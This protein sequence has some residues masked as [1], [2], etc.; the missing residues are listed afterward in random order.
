MNHFRQK[1]LSGSG[2]AFYQYGGIRV[3]DHIDSWTVVDVEPCRRLTLMMGM[4]ALGVGVLEFDLE[5]TETGGTRLT[6]TAYWHPAGLG[7]LVYWYSLFPAHLF[8][9]DKMTENICRLAEQQEQLVPG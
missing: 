1:I 8:I 7:G 2:S 3:G 4:K 6:A 9:F 5:A